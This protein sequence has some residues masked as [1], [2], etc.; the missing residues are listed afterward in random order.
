MKCLT[1]CPGFK[2][3]FN[4]EGNTARMRGLYKHEMTAVHKPYQ[5][6]SDSKS[7]AL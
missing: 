6:C 7:I 3:N 2:Q 5:V 4:K 1:N